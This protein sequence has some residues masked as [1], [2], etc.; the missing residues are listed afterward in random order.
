M[1]NYFQYIPDV[2]SS[3]YTEYLLNEFFAEVNF[4]EAATSHPDKFIR[5]NN[6]QSYEVFRELSSFLSEKYEFPPLQYL[7]VFYHDQD[8]PIHIDGDLSGYRRSSLNLPL[9]GYKNTTMKWYLPKPNTMPSLHCAYFFNKEDVTV[10]EELEGSNKWVLVNSEI[11]HN[12]VGATQE[13]PRI[14][15]CLRFKGNPPF[16]EL[17]NLL[18]KNSISS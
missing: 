5:Y 16:K 4:L 8:Q 9:I 2:D 10:L 6:I 12:I 15:A 7:N 18:N 14:T 13:M 11:A 1:N 17:Q 3:K